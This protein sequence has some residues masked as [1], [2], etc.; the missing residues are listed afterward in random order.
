M[1]I[2]NLTK[3][4]L[5]ELK[6]VRAGTSLPLDG[7]AEGFLELGKLALNVEKAA[8]TDFESISDLSRVVNEINTPGF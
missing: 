8:K 5:R 6:I 2:E 3:E 7:L 4:G 1:L